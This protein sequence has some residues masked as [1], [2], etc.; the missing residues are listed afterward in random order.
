MDEK[1]P[2]FSVDFIR[3]PDLDCV[4]ISIGGAHISL[5]FI[6]AGE[7]IELKKEQ[8]QVVPK[9]H[10]DY[11]VILQGGNPIQVLPRYEVLN[12]ME[13]G[14]SHNQVAWQFPAG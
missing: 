10:A 2:H 12:L 11:Y 6:V 8:G 7:P 1:T 4:K 14:F 9:K 5:G 13:Q 3:S